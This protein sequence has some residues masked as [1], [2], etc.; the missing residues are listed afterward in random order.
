M[1]VTVYRVIFEK[2]KTCESVENCEH[3]NI[4]ENFAQRTFANVNLQM[5]TITVGILC[6]LAGLRS[7]AAAEFD[8]HTSVVWKSRRMCGV[9]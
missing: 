8:S 1:Y 6:Y 4:Y 2:K 3:V 5:L 7:G 9:R